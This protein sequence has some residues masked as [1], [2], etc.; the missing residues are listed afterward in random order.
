M[1]TLLSLVICKCLTNGKQWCRKQWQIYVW[2][3]FF[4]THFRLPSCNVIRND[5]PPIKRRN[6][7]ML[8]LPF[9]KTFGFKARE[10]T[11]QALINCPVCNKSSPKSRHLD[12]ISVNERHPF[13]T[14]KDSERG[15]RKWTNFRKRT[16]CV[17]K[18]ESARSSPE[19]EGQCC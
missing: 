11:S 9:S 7:L 4:V 16:C 10:C 2:S 12:I 8:I 18:W 17:G 6:S 15:F 5:F 19:R 14:R 13:K 3:D 1:N